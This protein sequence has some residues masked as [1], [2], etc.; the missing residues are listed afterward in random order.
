MLYTANSQVLLHYSKKS[1]EMLEQKTNSYFKIHAVQRLTP[2]L[3]L[4][5]YINDVNKMWR[6][7]YI[8]TFYQTLQHPNTLS[9]MQFETE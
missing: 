5:V 4:W 3:V 6:R 8:I 2:S 7:G 9:R 1:K